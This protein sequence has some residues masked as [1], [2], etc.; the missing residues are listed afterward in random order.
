MRGLQAQSRSEL[1]YKPTKPSLVWRIVVKVADMLLVNTNP[2][3]LIVEHITRHNEC[4]SMTDDLVREYHESGHTRG[5]VAKA[6][7]RLVNRSQQTSLTQTDFTDA[8]ASLMMSD[9]INAAELLPH[10]E[11]LLVL[12][13]HC[14][15]NGNKWIRASYT[16]KMPFDVLPP[17]I[18]ECQKPCVFVIGALTKMRK[19]EG[20]TAEF[21]RVQM[22]YSEVV[23]VNPDHTINVNPE[24]LLNEIQKLQLL[25]SEN[26][27][28]T[29][30][31]VKIRNIPWNIQGVH[32]IPIRDIGRRRDLSELI[33]D[34]DSEFANEVKQRN[35]ILTSTTPGS[36]IITSM[37]EEDT[38]SKDAV[39]A[40]VLF[41][42]TLSDEAQ[43]T[44]SHQT[45]QGRK[46]NI[47]PLDKAKNSS[48]TV[49]HTAKENLQHVQ[50]TSDATIGRQQPRDIVNS[51][52]TP[53]NGAL[54]EELKQRV[55]PGRA[56]ISKS[57]IVPSSSS[58]VQSHKTEV[59]D[60]ADRAVVHDE[61]N[62]LDR[63]EK[64]QR[65]SQ[66]LADK[67]AHSQM[68]ADETIVL[69]G[70]AA[71][72]TTAS[73]REKVPQA[74]LTGDRET[75]TQ[76]QTEGKP[77]DEG[78]DVL[79]PTQQ[80]ES[81]AVDKMIS[82]EEDLGRAT[83]EISTQTI[84]PTD[85]HRL[86]QLKDAILQVG[87]DETASKSST[88]RAIV[89]THPGTY[90]GAT[91]SVPVSG[92]GV[93]VFEQ[94]LDTVVSASS[95]DRPRRR[96]RRHSSRTHRRRAFRRHGLRVW[97]SYYPGSTFV[98]T[99][100]NEPIYRSLWRRSKGRRVPSSIR[101]ASILNHG[102]KAIPPRL[103]RD[104]GREAS[105][106]GIGLKVVAGNTT[107]LQKV[108]PPKSSAYSIF[109]RVLSVLSNNLHKIETKYR[110]S[111]RTPIIIFCDSP[112]LVAIFNQLTQRVIGTEGNRGD[113]YKWWPNIKFAHAPLSS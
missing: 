54:M 112:I 73:E 85:H 111:S 2:Q 24:Q 19:P 48:D 89:Q 47:I 82:T 41:F 87:T 101:Y 56:Q 76:T 22:P 92:S 71:A 34:L 36:V 20:S 66:R 103:S 5:I 49:T 3:G 50:N 28:R 78:A 80:Q 94:T 61:P 70:P 31:T 8:A 45:R 102:F 55:P 88:A 83:R 113:L 32:R 64:S 27:H 62:I 52:S 86:Q 44:F 14:D 40:K 79:A 81:Q 63:Q 57:R 1:G 98:R 58:H 25:Q 97:H 107:V 16:D 60:E 23:K 38:P 12:W 110:D 53:P 42:S 91:F 105:N 59:R 29:T 13:C 15:V 10:E 104:L 43:T 39:A 108:L 95:Q 84:Q 67:H 37:A 65:I 90:P 77:L 96:R 100:T 11:N 9:P 35:Q 72:T 18:M 46:K 4:D 93:G 6:I 68:D 69:D 30:Q 17:N 26:H 74:A 21:L 75:E 7:A 99:S 109:K 51:S 106:R 33:N